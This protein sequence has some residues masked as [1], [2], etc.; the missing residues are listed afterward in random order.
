MKNLLLCSI[1]ALSAFSAYAEETVDSD[2]PWCPTDANWAMPVT[3][4]LVPDGGL[5]RVGTR[6]FRSCNS[7]HSTVGR[8]VV[9]LTLNPAMM[10]E[11]LTHH[12]GT[13]HFV[14]DVIV[15][16]SLPRG[17]W[18]PSMLRGHV[19]VGTR[20][21]G[22]LTYRAYTPEI[23]LDV[24]HG[25]RTFVYEAGL[26]P[27][28]GRQPDHAIQCPDQSKI[29]GSSLRCDVFV[30]HE[31]IRA[32]TTVIGDGIDFPPLPRQEFPQIARDVQAVLDLADVTSRLSTFEARLPRFD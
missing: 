2:V 15:S 25:S 22:D 29:K 13:A 11:T 10:P 26:N 8:R 27:L 19:A 18:M 21:F 28:G 23:L 1:I 3:P 12:V 7:P 5:V 31:D 32:H 16:D 24:A 9:R 20:T 14:S 17:E 4:D 6:V 30:F